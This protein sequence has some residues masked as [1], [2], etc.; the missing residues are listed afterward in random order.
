MPNRAERRKKRA[1]RSTTTPAT[2][3]AE[4]PLQGIE[5]EGSGN[6]RDD[7]SPLAPVP[8]NLDVRTV[9]AVDDGAVADVADVQSIDEVVDGGAVADG[10]DVL[11]RVHPVPAGRIAQR[12]VRTNPHLHI[13]C[14]SQQSCTYLAHLISVLL[15]ITHAVLS[16]LSVPQAAVEDG[17][18]D[19][20]PFGAL[21]LATVP[22]SDCCSLP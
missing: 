12:Q 7:E 20:D 6:A 5:I 22:V 4:N 13:R 17:S 16:V 8:L 1:L 2:S 9:A 21:P 19:D 11:A 10:D 18:D 14:Y 15:M 3:L